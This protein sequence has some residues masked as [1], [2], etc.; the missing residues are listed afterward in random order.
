MR[1]TTH[2]LLLNFWTWFGEKQHHILVTSSENILHPKGYHPN[3]QR[4]Y[5]PADTVNWLPRSFCYAI[6]QVLWN[7]VFMEISVN[8]K[9][10]GLNYFLWNEFLDWK[11]YSVRK[12]DV[13]RHD[14]SKALSQ[15]HNGPGEKTITR[16]CLFQWGQKTVHSVVESNQYN[17]PE[18]RLAP[19]LY[20]IKSRAPYWSLLLADWH[21]AIV[22]EPGQ[23][24]REAINFFIEAYA[25]IIT[26]MMGHCLWAHWRSNITRERSW[27]HQQG[28][29]SGSPGYWTFGE[30][31]HGTLRFHMLHPFQ[32]IH[33]YNSSPIILISK[34]PN[35]FFS[36]SF[37][38]WPN[39]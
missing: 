33:S 8:P 2:T 31:S 37:T 10:T 13:I 12:H 1:N 7:E 9:S 30:N 19:S 27:L 38:G 21:L 28:E 11:Q 39:L 22:G 17:Q 4:Y 32:E 24:W 6:S 14:V 16:L 26:A 35:P 23:P 5:F 18:G 29:S 36:T 34:L 15:Q 25:I 20:D 3:A